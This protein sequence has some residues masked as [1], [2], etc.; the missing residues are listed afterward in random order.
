MENYMKIEVDDKWVQRALIAF[1]GFG[2]CSYACM[3][4][5]YILWFLGRWP[6]S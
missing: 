6:T 5:S 2:A 4:V 3:F 1:F